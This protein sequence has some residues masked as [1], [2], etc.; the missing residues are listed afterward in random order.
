MRGSARVWG[1]NRIRVDMCYSGIVFVLRPLGS[2]L[3]G[4]HVD[5]FTCWAGRMADC[6]ENSY[7][8]TFAE[9]GWLVVARGRTFNYVTR[10]SH[11]LSF[12]VSL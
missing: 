10:H 3:W 11:S 7:I 8:R 4:L 1:V 5:G 6:G 9:A 2:L 12:V